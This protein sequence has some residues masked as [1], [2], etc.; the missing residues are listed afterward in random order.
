MVGQLDGPSVTRFE[1][2]KMSGFLHENQ[3]DSP[4]LTSL[5]ELGMLGVLNVLHMPMDASLTSLG[6]FLNK[7]VTLGSFVQTLV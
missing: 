1:M 6:L 7:I 4:T 2:P 3:R 5:N